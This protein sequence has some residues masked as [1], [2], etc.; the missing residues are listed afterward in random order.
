MQ[1]LLNLWMP[2]QVI[3]FSD[4]QRLK[5]AVAWVLKLKETL[6]KL[7]KNGKQ[8]WLARANQW[9]LL[10]VCKEMQAYKASLGNQ[11]LSLDDL[12]EA[13]TLII[14]FCQ[15]E[16]SWWIATTLT[17]SKAEVKKSSTIYK[18]D[19]IPEEGLL[20]VGGRLNKATMPEDLKHPLILS[21]DQHISN[22]I[23]RHFHE[24]LGHGGRNHVL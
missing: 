15:R 18:L 11:S 10:D 22:H 9:P 14:S 19:T 20:R 7:S 21:K 6:L 13:K 4:W 23:L 17:S 2:Q 5:A 24:E 8:F 16:I 1:P 3:Y 12:S